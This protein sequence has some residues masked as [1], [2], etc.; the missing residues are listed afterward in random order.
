VG[1]RWLL[2][3]F[4]GFH[5]PVL[6][7]WAVVGFCGPALAVVGFREPVLASVGF[8]WLSW[9]GV[10]VMGCRGLLRACVRLPHWLLLAFVGPR[11]PALAYALK[12]KCYRK[13]NIGEKKTH[14]GSFGPFSCHEYPSIH[15]HRR[16]RHSLALLGVVIG[17]I[18]GR[19]HRR[20]S[21]SSCGWVLQSTVVVVV[22]I[23][24][25]SYL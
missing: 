8:R 5:G 25:F 1:Q 13:K 17:H 12:N 16:R 10:A 23:A 9:A 4:V 6:L 7:S 2:W 21:L 15:F 3:A 19:R 24:G 22:A 20:L 18:V 11:S 14:L